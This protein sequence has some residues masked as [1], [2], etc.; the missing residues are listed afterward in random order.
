VLFASDGR[1]SSVVSLQIEGEK[2][3]GEQAAVRSVFYSNA[4]QV[5][6]S[7][8]LRAG[9]LRW[10]LATLA[11]LVAFSIAAHASPDYADREI[12]VRFKESVSETDKQSVV[13]DFS[14]EEIS[15]FDHIH[16]VHYRIGSDLTVEEVLSELKQLPIVEDAEPNYRRQVFSLPSDPLVSLQWSLR[17]TGQIVNGVG[18]LGGFDISLA[19]ALESFEPN[20]TVVVAV[21]D[22]G[23]SIDHP[24]I[25]PNYWFNASELNGVDGIDDDNN[26][27]V[28]DVGGWDFVDDDSLPLDENG[29]GT[30]VASLIG[31]ET[32]NDD[33]IAGVS[34]NVEIMGLRVLDDFGFGSSTF[35][36]E[37][38]LATTYAV[39]NGADIINLS[40]GGPGFSG[41][42]QDQF[43]WID[44]NGVLVVAAAGNGGSDGF[45]DNNDFSPMYPASYPSD[46]IISV[47]ALNRL[48]ELA[49]FS[50]YGQNS[51]DIA[52]PGTDILGADVSRSPF[53]PNT[54]SPEGFESGAPGW[55]V[56]SLP[57][58]QSFYDW[59]LWSLF[60]NNLLTDS[61]NTFTN[62]QL[63]YLPNTN[64]FA[65][66]PTISLIG[67]VGA[68]LS[69][70]L[71]YDLEYFF[72]YFIVEASS[73]GIFWDT[74]LVRTGSSSGNATS[75]VNLDIS[76]YEG[77]FIQLRFRLV[78]DSAG[79][80]D[81]VAIDNVQITEV[82]VFEYD[83]TQYDF[84]NGT[85][86]AAPLVAGVAA[87][88]MSTRPDLSHRE[89]RELILQN[90]DVLSSLSPLIG[91]G[92]TLN[93]EAALAAALAVQVD[94]DADNVPDNEDAFPLD[95]AASVDSD[96]DGAPDA[97][98]PG[99]DQS[100]STS[101]PQLFLD[102]F[103]QDA[104]EQL[105]SDADGLGD[106][107]ERQLGT[108]PNLSDTDG[109]GYSDFDEVEGGT[110]PI[111]AND[112][113]PSGLNITLVYL[114]AQNQSADT[115]ESGG[116]DDDDG[117]G[118]VVVPGCNDTT[119]LCRD[120]MG[121]IVE[122][123]ASE[124]ITFLR[125]AIIA[126]NFSVGTGTSVPAVFFDF[127]PQGA[128]VGEQRVWISSEPGG[129]PL[130]ANGRCEAQDASRAYTVTAYLAGR[131]TRDDPSRFCVINAGETYYLNQELLQ[132]V[133][134]QVVIRSI[135]GAF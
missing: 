23:V 103:P 51:V 90:G 102:A 80:R 52:A 106:N 3:P 125:G 84:S 63:T 28:D 101:V 47:A 88:I 59:S 8:L 112:Y 42:L 134:S 2:M 131:S 93:A 13:E 119:V 43:A 49:V 91:S 75:K 67:R 115:G 19:G 76:R 87:L 33:G 79:N 92:A 30:L 6:N 94:T 39:Q 56:G 124:R 62:S 5:Q 127:A 121:T 41:F 20:A 126:S 122:T 73:D 113:P 44:A 97:W 60:G 14:L 110:S 86:F 135:G 26:G 40:L 46:G 25:L 107:R 85:S 45:G 111:D 95:P 12:L 130:Q 104:S 74:L 27:Y 117:E 64:T 108:N 50:N 81:G 120:N 129:A 10:L 58:N 54:F 55:T 99:R 98:N 65:L 35:D 72:D 16:V 70:D 118:T 68:Q 105:D 133:S 96:R 61:V 71:I 89:V 53:F 17:D 100:D 48:G 116:A 38:F 22:S 11:L 37:L 82:D 128:V 4:S 132:T 15:R 7:N 32:F 83:G 34:P 1:V 114:A 77:Q 9:Q 78:T 69:F 66:S 21:I 109:D 18:G 57:G 31:A 24:D 29:H 36:S 123:V